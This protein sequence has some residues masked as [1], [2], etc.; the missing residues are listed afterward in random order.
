MSDAP[1]TLGRRAAGTLALTALLALAGCG[2]PATGEVTGTVTV[3]GQTPADGSSITFVPAEGGKSAGGGAPITGG[4]YAVTIPTGKYKV[5]IR[6]PRPIR[7]GKAKATEGPGPGGPANI[8]E[9]LPAKYNDKSEL[10]FEV[11]SGKNEKNWEL[12]STK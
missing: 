4:K 10:T 6:A 2:G 1:I 7:A 11:Q 8:E 5:E 9:S 12:S 3:D